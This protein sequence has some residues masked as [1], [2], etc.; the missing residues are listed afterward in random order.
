MLYGLSICLSS[1]QDKAKN[2]LPMNGLDGMEL[3]AFCTA[4]LAAFVP[5]LTAFMVKSRSL[6]I[7]RLKFSI[8]LRKMRVLKLDDLAQMF[9]VCDMAS[10]VEIRLCI[11]AGERGDFLIQ[12]LDTI[13][14]RDR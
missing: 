10:E 2:Q 6:S 14:S 5:S 1:S 9:C 12:L 8:W 11:L 3:A 13:G 7:W 4:E